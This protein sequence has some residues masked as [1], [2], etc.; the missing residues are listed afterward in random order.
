MD[1]I[2][3]AMTTIRLAD[4]ID[5]ASKKRLLDSIDRYRNVRCGGSVECRRCDSHNRC[6]DAIND[7][8]GS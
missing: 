7:L 5:D 3:D 4:V 8:L 1:L 2:T 6:A